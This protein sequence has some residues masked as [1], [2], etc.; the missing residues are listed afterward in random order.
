MNNTYETECE[1]LKKKYESL[2]LQ[3]T[4]KMTLKCLVLTYCYRRFLAESGLN[5]PPHTV[6]KQKREEILAYLSDFTELEKGPT[7]IEELMDRVTEEAAEAA[8]ILNCFQKELKAYSQSATGYLYHVTAL[9]N[10]TAVA[11]SRQCLNMYHTSSDNAVFATSSRLHML[12]Y[13]GR[14]L[15]EDMQTLSSQRICIYKNNPFQYETEDL[16]Y[17]RHPVRICM[18]NYDDFIPVVDFIET[19]PGNFRICF[20]YEWTAFK[21][22]EQITAAETLEALNKKLLSG[23]QFYTPDPHGLL[24]RIG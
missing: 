1:H 18:L 6:R 24:K 11:S 23:Y 5:R 3:K 22:E 17:L 12:L 14:A 15:A 2:L 19:S 4:D 16:W 9:E 21:E 8:E 13:A 20:E 7:E 10:L